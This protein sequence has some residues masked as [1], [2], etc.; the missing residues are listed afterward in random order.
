M[1]K[2][3]KRACEG[4]KRRRSRE[5]RKKRRKRKRMIGKKLKNENCQNIEAR[6]EIS[7]VEGRPYSQR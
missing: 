4:E 7:W 5:K 3:W 6:S 1:S 2:R